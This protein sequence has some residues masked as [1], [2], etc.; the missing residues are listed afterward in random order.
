MRTVERRA[1][2]TKMEAQTPFQSELRGIWATLAWLTTDRLLVFILFLGLFAMAVRLP[3]DTDTWW[4]LRS[5]QYI[6][7]TGRIPLHDPFSHTVSG[8]EWIDSSWLAQLPLWAIY[9]VAGAGGLALGLALVVLATFVVVFWQCEGGLY[10]RAFAVL[11]AAL[12]SALYWAARPQMLSFF[13]TAVF[14]YI[15][16][17][18]K[19]RGINRLYLIPALTAVWVNLHGG[20][21]VGFILLGLYIVGEA[22]NNVIG[23]GD[24]PILSYRQVLTLIGATVV[25]LGAVLI[26]P[27][28]WKMLTYPFFTVSIGALQDFIQE[29]A[30]PDFHQAYQQPFLWMLLALMAAMALSR[31]RVD[32]TDLLLTAVFAYMSLMAVRHVALFAVVAA[33]VLARHGESALH[34]VLDAF[35][36]R[37]P[38]GPWLDRLLAHRF[39][40]TPLMVALHW[41]LLS[42]MAL[43]VLVRAA[44]PFSPAYAAA[45]L[46]ARLPVK[47]ADFIAQNGLPRELFNP[48]NWGGYLMWRLYPD[49]PVF[50]DGRTDLYDDAFIRLYLRVASGRPGW[51]ETLNDYG[52][53]TIVAERGSPLSELLRYAGGWAAV[54]ADNLAVIF[55]RDTVANRQLIERHGLAW[56]P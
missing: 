49:Y 28:T 44:Q 45:E 7:E 10:V 17:L 46:E 32:F 42:V 8:K 15:L 23:L 6:V 52:V 20:V 26:N 2:E 11:L 47:A 9:R 1:M 5:G 33:P 12:T 31:F 25:S 55:V 56:Q 30:S 51:Q 38:W 22:L 4:H 40:C 18:Y 3:T 48:Y 13:L 54:Y 35:R 53:E 27:N 16:Y 50:I 21:A 36:R 34:Q 43:S 29:W 24:A 39:P 41:A 14:L 37:T 19:R